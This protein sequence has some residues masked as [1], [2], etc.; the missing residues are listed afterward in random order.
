MAVTPKAT[1]FLRNLSSAM[2]RAAYPRS[3]PSGQSAG[4]S[5]KPIVW[6]GAS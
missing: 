1:A 5:F 2:F 4:L 6:K 3:L